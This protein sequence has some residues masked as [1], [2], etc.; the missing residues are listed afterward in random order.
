MI[1]F[2]FFVTVT[3]MYFLIIGS[4]KVRVP[5]VATYVAPIFVIWL[6]FSQDNFYPRRAYHVAMQIFSGF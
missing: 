6:F 1:F 5:A 3:S 4:S 2:L